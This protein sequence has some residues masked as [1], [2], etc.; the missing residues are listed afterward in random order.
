MTPQQRIDADRQKA[1]DAGM[2]ESYI[3]DPQRSWNNQ[4]GG[5]PPQGQQLGVVPN[6]I[7]NGRQ[8]G[9]DA[10]AAGNAMA[11]GGRLYRESPQTQQL[12]QFNQQTPAQQSRSLFAKP[13]QGPTATGFGGVGVKPTGDTS[14]WTPGDWQRYNSSQA[15]AQ[16]MYRGG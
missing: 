3:N 6:P 5:Q 1:I 7:V 16:S 4:G 9:Y 15:L 8:Q 10:F 13:G 14:T 12:G 11:P 2:P